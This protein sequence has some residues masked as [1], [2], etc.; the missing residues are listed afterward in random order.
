MIHNRYARTLTLTGSIVSALAL[1]SGG[2]ALADTAQE[3]TPQH[4]ERAAEHQRGLLASAVE[5]DTLSPEQRTAIEGLVGQYRDASRPVRAAEGQLL[6][7]LAQQVERSDT[8][9]IDTNALAPIVANK[10]K[11]DAAEA[12]VEVDA[13]TRLHALL[14]A[15]QRSQL[16]DAVEAEHGVGRGDAGHRPD[17]HRMGGK[18]GDFASLSLTADQKAA[19]FANFREKT[20]GGGWKARATARRQTLES[21]RGDSFDAAAWVRSEARRGERIEH[22]AVAAAPVLTP[23]QRALLAARLRARAARATAG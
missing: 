3:S 4:A 18:M 19:I 1:F 8:T 15:A 6:T 14:T 2:T 20:D 9:S 21:F 17:H 23:V 10:E 5:L 13:L 11:A 22:F 16:V 7:A 12:A